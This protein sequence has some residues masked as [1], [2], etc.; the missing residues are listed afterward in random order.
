MWLAAGNPLRWS[1]AEP[2]GHG[3]AMK[4]WRSPCP[5]LSASE[6][7][8]LDGLVEIAPGGGA[9]AA[10]QARLTARGRAVLGAG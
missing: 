8:L 5:R 3:Q 2:R 4:A 1:A 10:A 6:D 9:M 7:A